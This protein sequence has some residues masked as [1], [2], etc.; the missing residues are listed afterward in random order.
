MKTQKVWFITGASSGF[1]LEIAEDVEAWK[2]I[3]VITDHSHHH[4]PAVKH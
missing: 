1:G 4:S 2:A 3:S